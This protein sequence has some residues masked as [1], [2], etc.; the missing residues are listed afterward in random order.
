MLKGIDLTV[1]KF[2]L[3]I[4]EKKP[5]FLFQHFMSAV[6]VVLISVRILELCFMATWN[7]E[8]PLNTDYNNYLQVAFSTNIQ[9]YSSCNYNMFEGLVILDWCT[10]TE[11]CF[12][13]ALF[14]W[15]A[16]N[17]KILDY[18]RIIPFEDLTRRR[19]FAIG[20]SCCYFPSIGGSACWLLPQS[21]WES[22][23]II[24]L[25][26]KTDLVA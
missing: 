16:L 9:P 14:S 3:H 19:F 5:L 4:A 24:F 25:S 17:T 13:V 12:S 15:C 6:Y 26:V 2:R 22:V 23:W 7:A 1:F 11:D 20:R 10:L 21:P 8:F 18:L